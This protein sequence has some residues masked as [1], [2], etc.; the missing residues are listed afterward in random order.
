MLVPEGNNK[1]YVKVVIGIYI[2]FVT[3]NPLLNLLNFQFDLDSI[4]NIETKQVYSNLD[5]NIKDVYVT[6]I[7]ETIKS[8]LEDLGY[9]V[10]NVCVYVDINYENIEKIELE[11]SEKNN[12]IKIEPI[13]IDNSNN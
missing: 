10:K 4:F 1:K 7:E 12:E 13:I 2:M 11:L 5:S 6:G 9:N 3:L 8:D